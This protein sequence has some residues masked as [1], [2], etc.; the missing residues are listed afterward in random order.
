M[1]ELTQLVPK[2]IDY[3]ILA[4]L[5]GSQG[6]PI[7]FVE[8]MFVFFSMAMPTFSNFLVISLQDHI[9]EYDFQ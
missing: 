6:V 1:N 2:D 7:G 3:T 5:F 8:I 4:S 9:Q